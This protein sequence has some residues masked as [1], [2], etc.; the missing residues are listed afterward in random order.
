MPS[1]GNAR[2]SAQASPQ[3]AGGCSPVGIDAGGNI[4]VHGAD[5]QLFSQARQGLFDQGGL[6]GSRRTHQ[7]YYRDAE[8]IKQFSVFLGNSAVGIQN[9]FNNRYSHCLLLE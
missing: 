9:I 6:T 3:S 4:P 8:C 7:V 1:I 5:T 2:S